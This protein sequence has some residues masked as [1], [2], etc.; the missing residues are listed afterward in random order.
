MR[1][2]VRA[3]GRTHR[4]CARARGGLLGKGTTKEAEKGTRCSPSSCGSPH[5]ERGRGESPST[6]VTPAQ[7][8]G[9]RN[10]HDRIVHGQG[11]R[12][13]DRASRPRKSRSCN[14]MC[15]E[16][17][18]VIYHIFSSINFFIIFIFIFCKTMYNIFARASKHA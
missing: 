3:Q 17:K 1:K 5:K 11:D 2:K 12:A 18:Y 8:T 9:A 7:N 4:V 10:I 13:R 15:D 14:V 16:T 6:L